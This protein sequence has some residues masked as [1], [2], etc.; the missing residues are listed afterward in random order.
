MLLSSSPCPS[1]R[2]SFSKRQ[3][4]V[5]A[6][7]HLPKIR[8][9]LPLPRPPMPI[10]PPGIFQRI[11][12]LVAKLGPIAG[13]GGEWIGRERPEQVW[14]SP[15]FPTV[16]PSGSQIAPT[17]GTCTGTYLARQG[18]ASIAVAAARRTKLSLKIPLSGAP[19][20]HEDGI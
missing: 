10:I 7:S 9:L 6:H 12:P 18:G 4:A 3:K 13:D 2:Y 5:A 16:S 1:A 8:S 19:R 11:P 17:A 14:S 20:R 15:T